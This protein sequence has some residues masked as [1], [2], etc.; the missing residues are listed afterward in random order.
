ME[1]DTLQLQC[2]AMDA[3]ATDNGAV[4]KTVPQ[5]YLFPQFQWLEYCFT[6]LSFLL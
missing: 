6:L 3:K 1:V 4:L 2:V 5:A